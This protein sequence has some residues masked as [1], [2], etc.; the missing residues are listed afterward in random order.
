MS[1]S[2]LVTEQD[3]E[4][5]ANNYAALHGVGVAITARS[6]G[7]SVAAGEASRVAGTAR[8]MTRAIVHQAEELGDVSIGP[9]QVSELSDE[10]AAAIASSL[11][12]V[13]SCLVHSAHARYLTSVVHEGA[14]ADAFAQLEEKNQRLAALVE[15]LQE[16]DQIKSAFLATVSHE[17]RTPLTS[18][19][20]YS[21]MLVEGLAGP[22]NDEQTDYL[23]T[24]LAKADQLLQI[25]TGILDVSLIESGS[26]RIR[27]EPLALADVV[28]RVFEAQGATAD[29]SGVA[30]VRE[31]DSGLPKVYGDRQKLYQIVA[32][33]VTNAIKF[34]PRGG[35]VEVS[36]DL[37]PMRHQEELATFS[38]SS[39]ALEGVRLT[40]RDAGIGIAPEK[41]AHIFEP[42]FQVDSSSTREYGGTGLGLTL[43]KSY[44]EAHGGEVWVDSSLGE[45][46][47]FTV[48]L[49]TVESAAAGP[50]RER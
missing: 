49:P 39:G 36:A 25:I 18:V 48:T 11:A 16:V 17:L 43:V 30:L 23:R 7:L 12:Q 38:S 41:L 8:Y 26:L 19:I 33:L 46:S 34:S 13:C 24:I 14:M 44:A 2:E 37:G 29:K 10:R 9:Y 28:G 4:E 21:E 35:K 32:H 47:A 27:Q 6:G 50:G 45:G 5:I 15:K 22:L 40:V 20:G 3:L 31:V 1:L 42:F